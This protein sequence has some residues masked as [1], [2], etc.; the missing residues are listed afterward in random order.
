[1]KARKV[2]SA[3][4]AGA[5]MMLC[6]CGEK[7]T[8]QY[9]EPEIEESVA[10]QSLPESSCHLDYADVTISLRDGFEYIEATK[11]AG[12]TLSFLACNDDDGCGYV[13]PMNDM[14]NII[15]IVG[16][17]HA[18]TEN[19]LFDWEFDSNNVATIT[20]SFSPAD[21]GIGHVDSLSVSVMSN[22][23]DYEIVDSCTAEIQ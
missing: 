2:I 20:G 15:S 9:S 10:T 5:I 12:Y 22:A 7:Q 19:Q 8:I 14:H 13:T 11:K 17:D 18:T 23:L 21:L 1:M 4:A 3:I 6:A 16:Q